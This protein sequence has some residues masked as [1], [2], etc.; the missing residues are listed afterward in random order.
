MNMYESI[1]NNLKESDDDS[2]RKLAED[3]YEYTTDISITEDEWF[4]NIE[5]EHPEL[6]NASYEEIVD[7]ATNE[8]LRD[9]KDNPAI[10][11]EQMRN[12]CCAYEY[13]GPEHEEIREMY[14]KLKDAGIDIDLN[15][16]LFDENGEP[17]KEDEN[18]AQRLAE[19]I[20][21]AGLV[22][23]YDEGVNRVV[24]KGTDGTIIKNNLGVKGLSRVGA[25]DFTYYDT[26]MQ[27][28]YI[29]MTYVDTLDLYNGKKLVASINKDE[30]FKESETKA[31]NDLEEICSYVYKDCSGDMQYFPDKEQMEYI[32]DVTGREYN[33][34]KQMVAKAIENV[35]DN[36]YGDY[37]EINDN[38]TK[39]DIHI[40]NINTDELSDGDYEIIDEH[41]QELVNE[42]LEKL[43]EFTLGEVYQDGRSGRHIVME[44]NFYNAYHYDEI[45]EKQEE[46]EQWVL[47]TLNTDAQEYFSRE[48]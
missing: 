39:L 26:D 41:Y 29:D 43:Q 17:L 8:I 44:D 14:R 15:G 45:R 9:L 4:D 33:K 6:K 40:D 35:A 5:A 7:F 48:E 21:S 32:A 30:Y 16:Y 36:F 24:I 13:D 19:V 42:A 11:Q 46:L 10:I 18:F 22:V 23:G 25:E 37:I 20:K 1:K 3:F 47:D 34:I 31:G 12:D 28:H 2:L 27:L 38:A